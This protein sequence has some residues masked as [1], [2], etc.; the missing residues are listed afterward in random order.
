MA[1]PSQI[2]P[3][4][5]ATNRFYEVSL[6][7]A[8]DVRQRLNVGQVFPTGAGMPIGY[9]QL[10]PSLRS[11]YSVNPDRDYVLL[12]EFLYELDHATSK[13]RRV[14]PVVIARR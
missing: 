3:Q 6:N 12:D 4:P 8:G 5:A 9:A 7:C 1:T 14:M 10:T 13:V 11:A 2:C